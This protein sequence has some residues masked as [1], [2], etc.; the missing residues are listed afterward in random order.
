MFQT[1]CDLIPNDPDMPV[2]ARRL[3]I[4]RRVLD[5]TLYDALPYDFHEER[6]PAGDYIPLR[7]RRPSV[8]YALPRIVTEDSV[9]LLFS[10]GHFPTIDSPVRAVRDAL[11]AIAKAVHLNEVMTEAALRGSI[12]SVALLLRIL[13][14][15]PFVSAMDTVYLTPV[16]R[17]DAPDTL[18]SVTERY[19]LPGSAFAAAGYVLPDPGG[20]YWFTRR[21]DDR[22]ETWFLPHPVSDPSPPVPDPG[23]S[24]THD[25]GFVPIVWVRNLPGASWTTDPADGASTFRAA[26]ETSIE[27][28]YQL[29]QA[30]RGLK[31][32]SDP[33][34]LIKEPAGMEGDLV[35]GAGNALIVSEHGDAK[36]LEIGGTASAAVIEYVRTLREF[37]MESVHGN[38]ADASRLSAATSGRALELMNQGLIWLADNLRISYGEGALLT[39]ARMFLRAHVKYKL[40]IGEEPLPPLDAEA[41]LSLIWPRWYPATAQDRQHDAQTLATLTAAKLLSTET[42][43]KTLADTY[44]VEDIPAELARIRSDSPVPL[45]TGDGDVTLTPPPGLNTEA[46]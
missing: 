2:R 32:S 4:L 22:T 36:L 37:A 42:A 8:R 15:R 13:G 45:G 44:D 43:V 18:A 26:I 17:Q 46:P 9:A 21:W 1:I 5:G 19:K 10:E 41:S 12:G 23:R 27:I 38:R 7:L 24:T 29:S 28:D 39:L 25:L 3:D 11:T 31:Y 30:G 34:L 6:T 14:G 35:R 16:W 40:R 20:T 33:T